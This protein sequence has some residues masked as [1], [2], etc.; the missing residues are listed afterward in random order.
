VSED[1]DKPNSA[2]G[3]LSYDSTSTGELIT[4]F[5]RNISP[6]PT[7]VGGPAFDLIPI[8]KQK[9][10]MVN[11]SRMH[12]KQEY[13]RIMELVAVLQRQADDVRKRLDITDL[14]HAAQYSFQIYH[15]QCY[16]LARDLA[17]GG[18]LLTQTGPTEWTTTKPDHYEYI[19]R[20]KWLGDYT[21]IEVEE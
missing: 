15:G 8:E 20:V 9:D 4:F 12:A 7:D 18:T 19:C 3:R 11:V 5:N 10:I 1:Q 2:D 16:W 13:N 21:W 14:V 6:Y 17:R